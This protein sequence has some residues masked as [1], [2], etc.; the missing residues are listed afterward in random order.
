MDIIINGVTLQGDFMDAAFAGPYEEA[1]R[2]LQIKA[3][4]SQKK[5]YA[6]FADS[7]REQC[8]VVDE[9]FDGIFGEG[10]AARVFEGAEQHLM[11]HL[12]AVEDLTNWAQGERKKLNDFTNR[13]TQRQNAAARRQQEP[14]SVYHKN[15]RKH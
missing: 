6:S 4:E 8:A 1:T 5:Q 11:V 10:T 15:G 2:R 13:Y 7:I 12:R 3:A 9:Y 14:F